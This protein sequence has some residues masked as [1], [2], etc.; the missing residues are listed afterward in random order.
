VPVV[1]P[2]P[3][4][5]P[6]PLANGPASRT[7]PPP[8]VAA[9]TPNC[10]AT[11][12]RCPAFLG[13]PTWETLLGEEAGRLRSQRDFFLP[14]H[15][16]ARSRPF[17]G[18]SPKPRVRLA[19]CH[20]RGA[21]AWLSALPTPGV[22]RTA[23]H[24]AAMRTAL[25]LWLSAP[26]RPAPPPPWCSF[27][28]A[29]HPDGCNVLGAGAVQRGRRQRLH[30]HIVHLL[31]AALRRTGVWR[32]GVVERRLDVARVLL[33]LD[34]RASRLSSGVR[35]CGN[36][37]VTWPSTVRLA[38][39]VEREPL[40]AA[41]VEPWEQDRVRKHAS[42]LPAAPRPDAFTP[43]VWEVFGRMR[44][45]T[46]A[47]LREALGTPGGSVIRRSFRTAASV[48]LWR[49]NARAVDAGY[50]SSVETGDRPVNSAE[51][52]TRPGVDSGNS[53]SISN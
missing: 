12:L 30:D 8:C 49:S 46:A 3:P 42:S 18:L 40:R 45:L 2:L 25:R 41:M 31:V 13:P 38:R 50:A 53:V 16:A 22:A 51:G 15:D 17:E 26:P 10:P 7:P 35:M 36:E 47:L 14:V 4:A 1:L 24:F 48:A 19:A 44:P 32:D 29:V 52:R 9:A 33:R 28:A 39:R 20:G 43:Q 11:G 6:A 27:R 34:V 23:I 37:S 5:S 21:A